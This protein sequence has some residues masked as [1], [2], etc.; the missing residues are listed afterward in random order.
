MTAE[1]ILVSV[2]RACV[3]LASDGNC[4]LL[5]GD[6][7]R[8]PM[9]VELDIRACEAWVLS[10]SVGLPFNAEPMECEQ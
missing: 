8:A 5:I 9:F 4:T 3:R 10:G 1:T 6:P 7:S 2:V